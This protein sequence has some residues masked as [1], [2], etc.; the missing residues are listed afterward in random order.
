MILTLDA[1]RR[2]TLPANLVEAAPGDHFEA[3]FDPEE[4]A[5]VFRR[6]SKNADWLTVLKE[7][8]VKMGALPPRSRELPKRLKL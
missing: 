5:V 1:K 7:C 6:L 2:L 4:D 8:P 3:V